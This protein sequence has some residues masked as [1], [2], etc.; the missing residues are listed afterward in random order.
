MVGCFASLTFRLNP[1]SFSEFLLIVLHVH[2]L[3]FILLRLSFFFPCRQVSVSTTYPLTILKDS[4][5]IKNT[6]GPSIQCVEQRDAAKQSENCCIE[7]L[8][9]CF[10]I[11]IVKTKKVPLKFYCL[12]TILSRFNEQPIKSFRIILYKNLK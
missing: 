4:R 12:W 11:T 7:M 2:Y 3:A 10:L 6:D 5:W 1:N 9:I 8:L